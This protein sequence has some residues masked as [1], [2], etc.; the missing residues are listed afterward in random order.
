MCGLI[1]SHIQCL[2][3]LEGK[4]CLPLAYD[5]VNP[6]PVDRTSSMLNHSATEPHTSSVAASQSRVVDILVS[7]RESTQVVLELAAKAMVETAT[8]SSFDSHSTAVR[9]ALRPF[10]DLRYG[11]LVLG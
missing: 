6:R 11:S 7:S 2:Q 1:N 10:D 9:T 4:T 8:R 3:P 5:P